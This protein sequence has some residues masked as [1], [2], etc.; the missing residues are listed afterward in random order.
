M[1]ATPVRKDDKGLTRNPES[2]P[3]YRAGKA[4]DTRNPEPKQSRRR[5]QTSRVRVTRPE[6]ST[7][8]TTDLEAWIAEQSKGQK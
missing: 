6:S 2:D 7:T 3:D 5:K 8:P 1:N 4:T